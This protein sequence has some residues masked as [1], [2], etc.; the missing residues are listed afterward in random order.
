M[1]VF[2]AAIDELLHHPDWEVWSKHILPRYTYAADDVQKV[3]S[4]HSEW[5]AA[6]KAKRAAKAAEEAAA[7]AAA[8]EEA[9]AATAAAASADE[10]AAAVGV[11]GD[12]A[13]DVAAEEAVVVV[14]ATAANTLK[15]G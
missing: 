2:N 5:F 3:V 14:P 15:L 4:E 6:L 1:Q 13:G 8:A 7:E 9:V 10:A 11:A 12:L